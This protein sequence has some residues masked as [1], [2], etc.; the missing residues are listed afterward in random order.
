ML[1]KR[2]RQ[3]IRLDFWF[4]VR[5]VVVL[6]RRWCGRGGVRAAG[7]EGGGAMASNEVG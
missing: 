4:W 3:P 7:D 2:T 5:V 1:K 6:R